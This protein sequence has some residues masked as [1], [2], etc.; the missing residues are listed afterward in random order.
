MTEVCS[1]RVPRLVNSLSA[2]TLGTLV[3]YLNAHT[4]QSPHLE[5]WRQS[6]LQ[7]ASTGANKAPSAGLSRHGTPEVSRLPYPVDGTTSPIT[8]PTARFSMVSHCARCLPFGSMVSISL[9]R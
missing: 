3:C 9:H 5:S 2:P 1:L 7:Y 6:P 4:G 8:F